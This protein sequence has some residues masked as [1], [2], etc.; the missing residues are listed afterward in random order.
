MIFTTTP[1]SGA[2]LY[3]PLL[4]AF[5][6]EAE[7]RDLTVE[8]IDVTTRTTL[9]TKQLYNTSSGQIDISPLLQRRLSWNPAATP[10][11][12]SSA[13]DRA[14]LIQVKVEGV[15]VTRRFYPSQQPVTGEELLLSSMPSSRLL[16]RGE[17]EEL[18]LP[19]G[20][21]RAEVE[22]FT[23]EGSIVEEFIS[24]YATEPA[25]FGVESEGWEE[26]VFR[27]E[28]RLY[29]A[30][31]SH[32]LHYTLVDPLPEGVRAAWVG[33]NGCIEHYTFPI[34][35]KHSELQQV[36]HGHFASGAQRTLQ[37][38]CEEQWQLL[39]AYEGRARLAA[40]AELGTAPEAWI[41]TG[42]GVY[43]PVVVKAAER[44]LHRHGS[45]TALEFT[46]STTPKQ[47][48]LWS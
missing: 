7:P 48:T 22:R 29:A 42:D 13:V 17:R 38:Q 3:G 23:S 21:L 31:S 28:V 4:Y 1:E 30:D 26:E 27:A 8:V 6:D 33:R 41:V 18:L 35:I 44:T 45:L 20:I 25:L 37:S 34:C 46:L 43:I 14:P 32:T 16:A 9:F 15:S 19:T 5:S 12:F 36:S 11:G 24:S 39:S 40:L 47:L 10:A 2:S